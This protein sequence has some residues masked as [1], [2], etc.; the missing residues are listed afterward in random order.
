MTME[1]FVIPDTLL[2][3]RTKEIVM[4]QITLLNHEE[5][6]GDCWGV[7]EEDVHD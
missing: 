7:G 6:D 5:T 1:A 2:A 3:S 4:D